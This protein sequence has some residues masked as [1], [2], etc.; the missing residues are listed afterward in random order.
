MGV[1]GRRLRGLLPNLGIAATDA[2]ISRLAAGRSPRAA[3]AR[4]RRHVARARREL[5]EYLA[6]RRTVI[7]V[8]VDLSGLPRFRRRVLEVARRIPFGEVRRYAWLARRIGRPRAARAVGTALARNP[9]P[10]LVPCHRVL[11]SDGSVSG[12]LF[13]VRVKEALLGFEQR[14]LKGRRRRCPE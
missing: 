5:A 11:R 4:G 8:P 12:Y 1:E 10:L 14:T 9:V 6:G 3:S 7:T 13:G 2:G